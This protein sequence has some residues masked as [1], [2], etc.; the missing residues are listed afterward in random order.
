MLPAHGPQKDG[1]QE[2]GQALG[3]KV[4]VKRGKR[5][6]ILSVSIKE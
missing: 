6:G 4:E 5:I 3:A 1:P 2:T